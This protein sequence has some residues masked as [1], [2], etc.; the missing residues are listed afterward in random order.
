VPQFFHGTCQVEVVFKEDKRTGG[1]ERTSDH[2]RKH[3]ILEVYY[4]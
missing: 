1:F 4:Y 3:S 2:K